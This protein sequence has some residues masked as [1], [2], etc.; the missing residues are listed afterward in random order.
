MSGV[1]GVCYDVQVSLT[2]GASISAVPSVKLRSLCMWTIV[3]MSS[4]TV[5]SEAHAPMLRECDAQL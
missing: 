4:A 1:L 2:K 3:T 5:S